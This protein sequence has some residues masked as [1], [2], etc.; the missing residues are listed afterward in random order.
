M[1]DDE[2]AGSLL[3]GRPEQG[4]LIRMNSQIHSRFINLGSPAPGAHT[5]NATNHNYGYSGA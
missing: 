2:L 4:A 1:L 5:A 3:G